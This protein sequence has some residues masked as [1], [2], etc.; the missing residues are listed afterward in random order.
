MIF[1][2]HMMGVANTHRTRKIP[3]SK[4]TAQCRWSLDNLWVCKP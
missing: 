2:D 1:I 3:V 4:Y